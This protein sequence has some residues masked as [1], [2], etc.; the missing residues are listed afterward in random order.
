MHRSTTPPPDGRGELCLRFECPGCRDLLLLPVESLR[1]SHR[2]RCP[3]CY[4][5]VRVPIINET[6]AGYRRIVPRI[7]A[8]V[9]DCPSCAAPLRVPPSQPGNRE[10]CPACRRTLLF[11]LVAV[12]EPQP[13]TPQPKSGPPPKIKPS[14]TSGSAV[15]NPTQPPTP[16][17]VAKPSAKPAPSPPA[18][19]EKPT[20]SASD[21]ALA[22]TEFE[23]ETVAKPVVYGGQFA[24]SSAGR[25]GLEL[26]SSP[27]LTF[28]LLYAGMHFL[29][30]MLVIGLCC[31]T[32]STELV[33]LTGPIAGLTC[34]WVVFGFYPSFYF[35]RLI[36]PLIVTTFK[37]PGCAE[38]FP[39]VSRWKCGCGYADHRERHALSFRCPKCRGVLGYLDCEQCGATILIR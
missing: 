13:V 39:A 36:T 6:T 9:V 26:S 35:S 19:V 22:I 28:W 14:S 29:L 12:S 1:R 17:P 15:P 7:Q 4:Q 24:S 8:K 3:K 33:A 20:K 34:V 31:L 38:H 5:P 27:R 37:C 18:I 2:D 11:Q 30:P 21:D 16:P 32:F 23:P 10:E 25:G